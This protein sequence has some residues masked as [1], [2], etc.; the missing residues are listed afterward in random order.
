MWLPDPAKLIQ[1]HLHSQGLD[2]E[3][4]WAEDLGPAPVPAGARLVRLANIPFLH[5]KPIYGDLIAVRPDGEG[6]LSW[7]RGGVPFEQV[8]ERIVEDGGRWGMILDYQPRDRG[9]D[10][11]DAFRALQAAGRK[12]EIVVERGFA[13]ENGE[14]GRA[15]LA[16]PPHLEVG[17]VLHF[18]DVQRL[19]VT[20]TLVHPAGGDEDAG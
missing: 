15:Y 14:P 5:A 12:A 13:P 8:T 18:L 10:A 20:L 19:P 16:V 6:A 17:D 2:R 3:G 11:E 7:D 9:E 4:V 1:I